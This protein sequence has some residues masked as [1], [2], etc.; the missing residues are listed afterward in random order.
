MPKLKQPVASGRPCTPAH[1]LAEENKGLV[2]HVLAKYLPWLLAD[3]DRMEDAYVAGYVALLGAA[4]RFDSGRGLKFST[5]AVRCIWGEI[6]RYL[7]EGRRQS[8][9][10][11][12]ALDAPLGPEGS[13]WTLGDTLAAPPTADPQNVVPENERFAD[14]LAVLTPRQQV[15]ITA[16]YHDGTAALDVAKA[17]GITSQSVYRIRADAFTRLK[18]LL[19][20][21]AGKAGPESL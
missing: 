19:H 12:E 7:R 10:P 11:C 14:L 9:L 2:W 3:P 6:Q 17:M 20:W 5:Y 18:R 15:V 8:L 1:R 4:E 16:L 13:G 21:E